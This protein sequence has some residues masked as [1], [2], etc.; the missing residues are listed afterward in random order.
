MS[1][2]MFVIS[3]EQLREMVFSKYRKVRDNIWSDVHSRKLS[4]EL[5]KEK[6]RVLKDIELWMQE[7]RLYMEIP[8]YVADCHPDNMEYVYGTELQD[9]I[10][11]MRGEP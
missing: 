4:E 1:E 7:Y 9:K 2:P 11:S 10:D 3:E 6:E 8:R 5:K